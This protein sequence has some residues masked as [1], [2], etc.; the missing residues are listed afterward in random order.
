MCLTHAGYKDSVKWGSAGRLRGWVLRVSAA[1]I[2][3]A[4]MYFRSAGSEHM[5][6]HYVVHY[7]RLQDSRRPH[8]D[9]PAPSAGSSQFL[10]IC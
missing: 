9:R 3:S 8:V 1:V 10:K 7:A 2:W 6:K 4:Q 5:P